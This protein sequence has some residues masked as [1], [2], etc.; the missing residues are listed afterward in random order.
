MI[1]YVNNLVGDVKANPR[2]LYRYINRKK[3]RQGIPPIK[4]RV[5]N[6]VAE[7]DS[8]RAGELIGQFNDAFNKIEYNE[9]LSAPFMNNIVVSTEGVI[10][11]LKGLNP[12]KSCR[13]WWASS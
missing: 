6:E 12:L 3:D 2:D 5:G 13:T 1:L 9:V 10:K 11:L 4:K 8:E 7:F